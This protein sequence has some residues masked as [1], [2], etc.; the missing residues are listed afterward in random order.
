MSRLWR[1]GLLP[2]LCGALVLWAGPARA[3]V[4][5]PRELESG[6]VIVTA[7]TA[8]VR[9]APSPRAD[10]ITVVE[11]GEIFLKQGRT[12]GWYYIKIGDDT[13]G[14]I[15]G[16]AISRYKAEGSPSSDVGPYEGTPSYPSYPYLGSYYEYPYYWGQPYLSWEWYVYDREPH[17]DR[18]W[19]HERD[20]VRDRYRDRRRDD[21]WHGDGDR[22]RSDNRQDD[23]RRDDNWHQGNDVHRGDSGRTRSNSQNRPATPRFRGPFQRR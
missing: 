10:V 17:R 4:V 13:F 20:T 22:P 21:T 16:R 11:K 5:Q 1:R 7:A 15:S 23:R 9:E 2:L 19:D 12:G 14:W 6:S 18:S 8:E 3:E